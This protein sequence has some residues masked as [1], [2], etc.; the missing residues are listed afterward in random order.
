MATLREI[1]DKGYALKISLDTLEKM[2]QDKQL[3]QD[4]VQ[5]VN[6]EIASQQVVVNTLRDELK[7]LL[8]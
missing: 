8:P 5:Q 6:A 2:Q 7:A 3:A 1:A 4:R